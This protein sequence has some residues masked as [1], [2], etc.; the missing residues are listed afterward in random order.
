MAYYSDVIFDNV[1]LTEI[2]YFKIVRTITDPIPEILLQNEKIARRDGSKLYHKEFGAKV[3]TIEGQI[4]ANS[5][6]N[7]ILTRDTLLRYLAPQ[8]ATLQLPVQD[9]NPREWTATVRNVIFSDVGGGYA[10]VSIEFIC[11][12][13]FGYDRDTRV[14]LNGATTTVASH[15]FSLLETVGGSGNA[16][17]YIVVTLAA[18]TGGSGKYI[19]LA[20]QR[21]DAIR[22]TNTF[23]SDSQ[24]IVD[25]KNRTVTLDASTVDY[26]GTFWELEPGDM[27]LN[28]SDNLTTRTASILMTYKRRY[29]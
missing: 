8:E 10:A 25:M 17:P 3:I 14:L 26:T 2:E 20:N 7:Y 11:S 1:D 9:D 5:R 29:L 22:V 27:T 13:P 19:E 23:A 6:K 21:G 24:L 4:Q 15:D 28:Y 12:D 16:V 18:A